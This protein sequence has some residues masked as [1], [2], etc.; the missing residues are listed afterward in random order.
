MSLAPEGAFEKQGRPGPQ[1]WRK[2]A[3]PLANRSHPRTWPVPSSALAYSTDTPI[4]EAPALLQLPEARAAPRLVTNPLPRSDSPRSRAW[5]R[6]LGTRFIKKVPLGSP[7]EGG[8]ESLS[9]RVKPSLERQQSREYSQSLSGPRLLTG[10]S[11]AMGGGGEDQVD[12]V[13][14]CGGGAGGSKPGKGTGAGPGSRASRGC[15]SSTNSG[16]QLPPPHGAVGAS[17]VC[18]PWQITR[19][20]ASLPHPASWTGPSQSWTPSSQL[21]AGFCSFPL[22][23]QFHEILPRVPPA[24]L[25][26]FLLWQ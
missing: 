11:L 12:P 1:G 13:A 18:R 2:Q 15:A 9:P 25:L 10:R 3:P 5:G 24:L 16:S 19:Q 7:S 8:R 14:L 21:S 17:C 23:S 26:R 22:Y 20:T 6:D 4:S